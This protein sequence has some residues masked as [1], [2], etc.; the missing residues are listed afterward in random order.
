M[1][2]F[3]ELAE[4]AGLEYVFDDMPGLRRVRRGNGFAYLDPAGE[5]VDDATRDWIRSLVIPPAWTDVWIAPSRKA[6][7]L[8]TGRD[9]AGR[10]Q[11][12]YHPDW[13]EAAGDLKFSRMKIFSRH[14]PSLR[15]RVEADLRRHELDQ[16]K[17]AAIAVRVL[18]Q[19]LIRVGN[20][21]YATENGSFGLTTLEADHVEVSGSRVEFEF[22]GKGGAEH[23]LTIHDRRLATLVTRCQDLSGDTLFSFQDGDQVVSLTPGHLNDY[24]AGL[25]R[26]RFTAKDFRTWG[27]SAAVTEAMATGECELIAAI[28]VAAERLGNTRAVCRSSYV[29]PIIEEAASD[30]R[31]E[32][33]WRQSR[34]G[35]WLNRSESA[36]RRLVSADG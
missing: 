20:R 30:G 15:R 4:S 5:P 34:D 12:L 24:I 17:V 18:D 23:N 27:A 1:T 9:K 16:G 29:H 35:R 10:K 33:A 32:K 22:T 31:L 19:T 21:R 28:D 2:G 36:L 26:N 11:Y 3:E 8:A 13:S 14:L 7:I 25:G 6:H